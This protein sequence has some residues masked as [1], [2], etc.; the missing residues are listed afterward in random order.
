MPYL[1][2]LI[3]LIILAIVFISSRN[4]ARELRAD[5]SD[6][7]YSG[8]ELRTVEQAIKD[9]GDEAGW[10]YA[11]VFLN[12]SE[13]LSI[14]NLQ[15]R[16]EKKWPIHQLM[17]S[18]ET[19]DMKKKFSTIRATYRLEVVEPYFDRDLLTS[20]C[21]H[22]H[23]WPDVEDEL[24]KHKLAV[25]VGA[26]TE[27]GP[28]HF[29]SVLSQ[30]VWALFSSCRQASGVVWSPGNQVL[31]RQAILKNFNV[32][33]ESTFPANLW[34]ACKTYVDEKGRSIGYTQGLSS[35][36]LVDFEAIDAPE[37]PTELHNRLSGLISY[38]ILNCSRLL[39]GDTI[40][41]DEDERIELNRKPSEIGQKGWVFQLSYLNQSPKDPWQ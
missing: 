14:E 4:S 8:L 11:I 9:A 41:V 3:V 36:G 18:I 17:G 35:F 39:N 7:D 21:K 40:G 31:S 15:R 32:D 23:F 19:K 25:V 30:A 12:G 10:L 1:L 22:N 2:L 37:N 38:S 28:L 24:L 33:F 20:A 5:E 16:M 26:K 29:S 27:G 13:G 34:V 6:E